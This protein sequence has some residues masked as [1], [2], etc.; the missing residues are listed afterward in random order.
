MRNIDHAGRQC[1]QIV[2]VPTTWQTSLPSVV[3]VLYCTIVRVQSNSNSLVRIEAVKQ[4][5]VSVCVDS[6]FANRISTHHV[7]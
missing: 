6:V 3:R 5:D 2:R 1:F 4:I 7:H